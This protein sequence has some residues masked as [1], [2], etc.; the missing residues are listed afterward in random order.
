MAAA[1]R[2]VRSDGFRKIKNFFYADDSPDF[3]KLVRVGLRPEGR[4][5]RAD[6]R[7]RA[8]HLSA[9]FEQSRTKRPLEFYSAVPRKPGVRLSNCRNDARRRESPQNFAR[10]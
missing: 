3:E 1:F 2:N 5:F 7:R 4:A 6:R 8:P 10:P 9:R